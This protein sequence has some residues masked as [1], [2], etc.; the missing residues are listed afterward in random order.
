MG[1]SVATSFKYCINHFVKTWRTVLRNC[2]S[3]S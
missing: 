3:G 1:L 2:E